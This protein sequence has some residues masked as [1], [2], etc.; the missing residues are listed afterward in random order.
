MGKTLSRRCQP[1]EGTQDDVCDYV[2]PRGYPTWNIGPQI[3]SQFQQRDHVQPR[4]LP[5]LPRSWTGC[6]DVPKLPRA[7]LAA[8]LRGGF[9]SGVVHPS[10]GGHP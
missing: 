3:H 10:G 4:L 7:A 2:L 9:G 8:L 1:L 6:A 5:D